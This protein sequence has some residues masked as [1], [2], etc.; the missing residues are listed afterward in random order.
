MS[1]LPQQHPQDTL[2]WQ[3]PNN[4]EGITWQRLAER[5]TAASGPVAYVPFP[6]ASWIDAVQRGLRPGD[7]PLQAADDARAGLRV[8]V[9]QHIRALDHLAAFRAAGITDLFWSHAPRR[10]QRIGELRLHPY[11]LF[12]VRCHDH[13]PRG[14]LQSPQQRRWLYSYLGF[15]QPQLY[16]HDTRL[17]L[18][19]L[20]PRPD[21]LLLQREEW[22]FEQQVYRQQVHGQ[23]PDVLRLQRL[24]QQA[25]EYVRAM[26]DSCFALCP[27]G[28]GPNSIRLWEALGYGAIPV[29]LAD[30]LQLP[31]AESLWRQ[32]AVF[33]PEQEAAVRALP[34]QL[35]ELRRQPETL[36]RMQRAGHEL[37]RRYGLP[38]FITDVQA[39]L[40]DPDA[41]LLER[42]RQRLASRLAPSGTLPPAIEELRQDDPAELPLQLRR[43]L[44][45]RGSARAVVVRLIDG[46]PPLQQT[47]RW[48][49][50]VRLCRALIGT[51]PRRAW[52]LASRSLALERLADGEEA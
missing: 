24:Q 8:T 36:Q 47:L 37:W 10:L 19:R 42:A 38:G 2:A 9:C 31:G 6:W 48:R 41:L 29:I 39:F 23:P 16:P 14:S 30:E 43:W 46:R 21:A 12:P 35:L 3:Q 44:R 11:P 34:Q 52:S 13:P 7:P 26:E 5:S 22:H 40:A 45:R 4:T 32:A 17:W 49:V 51:D 25:L 20:P 1:R 15:H 18:Q 27:S 33:V 28:A 50:A